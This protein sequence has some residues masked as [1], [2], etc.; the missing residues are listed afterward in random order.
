MA[1]GDCECCGQP[2]TVPEPIEVEA[3]CDHYE[4]FD[5]TDCEDCGYGLCTEPV[6]VQPPVLCHHCVE[7]GP[8]G[9]LPGA[10]HCTCGRAYDGSAC[11]GPRRDP[12]RVGIVAA[13]YD[14][15][16]HGHLRGADD[17]GSS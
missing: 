15:P 9:C 6:T 12:R 2:T 1:S 10:W 5:C 16:S 3:E 14:E 17:G 7:D 8:E 13:M 11:P 4:C